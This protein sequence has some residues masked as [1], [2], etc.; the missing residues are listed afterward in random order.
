MWEALKGP[1]NTKQRT[2]HTA[3]LSTWPSSHTYFSDLHQ[4]VWMQMGSFVDW[5]Q[6]GM[7]NIKKR[8]GILTWSPLGYGRI[9]TRCQREAPGLQGRVILSEKEN[10]FS[11]AFHSFGSLAIILPYTSG[12]IQVQFWDYINIRFDLGKFL[13]MNF[14]LLKN[15]KV[16]I[17][18]VSFWKN[19]YI[20][21][22]S[23][24]E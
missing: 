6:F 16:E 1:Q 15:Y 22:E 19:F 2:R 24:L 18:S 4:M 5:L 14:M 20:F 3:A 17:C 21:F 12:F 11:C 9:T 13:K 8:H 23:L 10:S 7:S